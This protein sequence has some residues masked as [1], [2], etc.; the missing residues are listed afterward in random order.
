MHLASIDMAIL[1]LD[2][3]D[4]HVKIRETIKHDASVE[5]ECQLEAK[6]TLDLV[7]R[8]SDDSLSVTL[9]LCRYP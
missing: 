4:I 2:W 3:M 8:L 9:R 1:K 6:L 7:T 5:G